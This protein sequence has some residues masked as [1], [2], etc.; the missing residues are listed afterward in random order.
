MG[1][2]AEESIARVEEE[3]GDRCDDQVKPGLGSNISTL[4]HVTVTECLQDATLINEER[5]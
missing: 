4:H 2:R 5:R 1:Q 3:A